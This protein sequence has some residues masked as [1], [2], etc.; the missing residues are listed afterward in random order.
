MVAVS[1][2]EPP[3]RRQDTCVTLPDA[4]FRQTS[5]SQATSL[6]VRFYE[7]HVVKTHFTESKRFIFAKRR[8]NYISAR[9][10]LEKN[11]HERMDK[12]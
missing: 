1:C 10:V 4:D 9:F 11:T 5:K 7:S 2:P 12:S 8:S 3:S 6:S